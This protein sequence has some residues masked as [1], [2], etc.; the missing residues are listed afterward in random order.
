MKKFLTKQNLE[1]EFSSWLA[2]KVWTS[3]V[4][5][6]AQVNIV[7]V[8]KI[9]KL[10]LLLAFH[11]RLLLFLSSFLWRLLVIL[12]RLLWAFFGK[13]LAFSFL[14]RLLV[15][16]CRLLFII[17]SRHFVSFC[18]LLI[19]LCQ[20]CVFL[21]TLCFALCKGAWLSHL[22]I[23]TRVWLWNSSRVCWM[24]HHDQHQDGKDWY[25]GRHYGL[26]CCFVDSLKMTTKRSIWWDGFYAQIKYV[27]RSQMHLVN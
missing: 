18:W 27:C 17:P 13:R 6:L 7:A 22:N 10:H 2:V 4:S 3:S 19:I 1:K 11:C 14:C 9:S 15:I 23:L 8:F 21:W 12:C 5:H 25:E 26:T 20:K 24:G 16:L